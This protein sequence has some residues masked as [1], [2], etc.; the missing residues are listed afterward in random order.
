M[1]LCPSR[2]RRVKRE[3]RPV[4]RVCV[5]VCVWIENSASERVSERKGAVN[6]KSLTTGE[7]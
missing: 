7:K 5:C 2:G 6:P 3:V 4:Y 1:L